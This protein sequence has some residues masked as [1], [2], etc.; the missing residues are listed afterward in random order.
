MHVIHMCASW[1]HLEGITLG[2]VRVGALLG[3]WQ[4]RVGR[5]AASLLLLLLALQS[6]RTS[7][8][9]SSPPPSALNGIEQIC[10]RCILETTVSISL[11]P[12]PSLS[13]PC[14]SGE[15]PT[16]ASMKMNFCHWVEKWKASAKGYSVKRNYRSLLPPH[17]SLREAAMLLSW[18]YSNLCLMLLQMKLQW[19]L[20]CI[21]PFILIL[22]LQK[23]LGAIGGTIWIHTDIIIQSVNLTVY[24]FKI[25]GFPLP[26]F[27]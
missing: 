27:L 20:I 1:T 8:T 15:I 19:F 24:R 13:L 10:Y 9:V 17:S 25:S 5:K 26:A 6:L 11:Q 7:G 18:V 14:L 22:T 12:L 3:R 23:L 16:L 21:W 4:G 2:K